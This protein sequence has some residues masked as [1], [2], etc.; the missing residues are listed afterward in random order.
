M[1]KHPYTLPS[2]LYL[3]T[4]HKDD[5]YDLVAAIYGNMCDLALI[6]DEGH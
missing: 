3:S 6:N 2:K 1:D 4:M 5:M